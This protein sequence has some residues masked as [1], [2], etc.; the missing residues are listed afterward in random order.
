MITQSMENLATAMK[1]HAKRGYFDGKIYGAYF[2]KAKRIHAETG[3]M[4][5]FTRDV[6]YH[7]SGF[8]K[9]P[10]YER[11]KQS[12]P[13][14]KFILVISLKAD[15]S[16]GVINSMKRIWRQRVRTDERQATTPPRSRRSRKGGSS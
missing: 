16:H 12:S 9:N 11:G 15:G 5:L 7:T 2:A 8:F 14:A 10:D 6:G 1:K 3:A 13:E 4:L